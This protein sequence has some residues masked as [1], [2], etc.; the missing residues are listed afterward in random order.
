[1]DKVAFP[2]S[3]VRPTEAPK[4]YYRPGLKRGGP[5]VAMTKTL[6]IL[7]QKS[8]M[9]AAQALKNTKALPGVPEHFD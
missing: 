2:R 5:G 9:T 3:Q 6:W 1:M 7:V 4:G 8:P